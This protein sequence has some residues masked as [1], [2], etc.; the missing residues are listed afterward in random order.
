[1]AGSTITAGTTRTQAGATLITSDI[2]TINTSTAPSAGSMLG[3][4]VA[5]PVVGS[6]TDRIFLINNTA[7]PVQ[8]YGSGSDTVNGVA[9]ATGIILAPNSAVVAVEAAPGAWG[10]V[11]AGLGYSAGFSTETALNGITA[12]AGG[13]QGSATLLTAEINRVTT[14]ATAA[15][16]VLMPVSAP[17]L[18][19]TVTNATAT[20]SMNVFPQSGDAINALG[21]N[22]AFAVAAGKTATLTCAVAGQWHAVLSA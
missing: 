20:N 5:L 11:G 6:G 15:D 2:T 1:M 17:G 18:S 7:N 3:D 19:I 21:A 10:V 14:V 22:A 8:M 16:S 9:A 4:G 13:G 12:H